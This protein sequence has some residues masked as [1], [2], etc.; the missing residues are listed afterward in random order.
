MAALFCGGILSAQDNL[1]RHLDPEIRPIID[2]ELPTSR[3]SGDQPCN[4]YLSFNPTLDRSF[5][6]AGMAHGVTVSP[7]FK[8]ASMPVSNTTER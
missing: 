6:G 5:H 2:K 7:N 3:R 4:V 8:G 1:P